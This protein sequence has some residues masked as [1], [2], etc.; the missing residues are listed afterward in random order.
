MKTV[1]IQLNSNE[2]IEKSFIECLDY[3]LV[4]EHVI[5]HSVIRDDAKLEKLDELKKIIKPD[6]LRKGLKRALRTL[7]RIKFT[8]VK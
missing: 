3:P 2:E 7:P 4:A 1:Q 5:N 8:R 6:F